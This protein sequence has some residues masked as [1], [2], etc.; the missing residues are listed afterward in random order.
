[1]TELFQQLLEWVSLHPGWSSAV[2]FI[3]AMAESLAIIGLV[4]P[5]VVIMFGIGALISSGAIEFWPAMGWAV[6]GAI[7]GDGF[8]FWLGVHYRH[9]LTALWPF[10]K[11][12]E[13]LTRGIDFFN[14]YG[15]KSVAIG[16]FFGPV[17]AVIPLV[18]GMM[19]MPASRFLLANIASALVWAPAYLLPGIVFGASLELASAVAVRLVAIILLLVAVIWAS[20]VINRKLFQQIAPHIKH[21][22]H[23]LLRWSKAH[24]I[25]GDVA[26]ALVDPEH[27]E[28][29]GL[30]ILACL[31]LI[32]TLL[33]GSLIYQFSGGVPQLAIDQWTL[34]FLQ[35]LRSPQADQVMVYLTRFTDTG[36]VM[37]LVIG[38]GLFL[39]TQKHHRTLAYWFAAAL[40]CLLVSPILK[41]GLQIPRPEIALLPPTSYSF[42]S[43]HTLK[44]V[45]LYGF[46]A[47]MVG[48]ALSNTWRWLPYS[49][50]GALIVAIAL[51][52][53]YLGV[54]WLSD[55]LGSITLGLA[56]VALLGIA[57]H[58]HARSESHWRPLVSVAV[59]VLAIS[60]TLET[61]VSHETRLQ[62]YQP[63]TPPIVEIETQKWQQ[64]TANDLNGKVNFQFAGRLEW[65]EQQLRAAG[66]QRATLLSGQN[67]LKLLS[68]GLPLSEIPALPKLQ[69]GTPAEL[70]MIKPLS[71]SSQLSIR[72]WP[73]HF[74]LNPE[75]KSIWLGSSTIEIKRTILG[76][77]S[78]AQQQKESLILKT[79]L[80]VDL[81]PLPS[82]WISGHH[83]G[84]LK[85]DRASNTNA[86]QKLK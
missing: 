45:V 39:L 15:G 6:A 25:A 48:R 47:V 41:M 81:N 78:Y 24:P 61:V 70:Q 44:A 65:L 42:P 55:I 86:P 12:P 40:F 73:T 51:S 74:Q 22:L 69:S 68:P 76:S 9:R 37:G 54:H 20:F 16:R 32:M 60:F 23:R 63:K 46:F 19:G 64:Q 43:G 1:M 7:T 38:V 11:H 3:V 13:T 67:I 31:L 52:R 28:A 35:N 82:N 18:A 17:R 21:W 57:Y 50:C 71:D 66:W 77:V 85:R 10:N 59:L 29:R 30:S 79:P 14:R 53:L 56:W 33:F 2:I 80:L 84:V 36:V 83:G 75:Q 58:H 8:S 72:L 34:D 5:G 27:P 26:A 49:L 4:V 62:H